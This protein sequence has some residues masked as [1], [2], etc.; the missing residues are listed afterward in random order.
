MVKQRV[1]GIWNLVLQNPM[2]QRSLLEEKKSNKQRKRRC[3]K[4]KKTEQTKI[5]WDSILK[6]SEHKNS[7]IYSK[8]E[9]T[10]S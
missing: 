8:A 3:H 1:T 2:I 6:N 10:L 5:A 7:Y 9:F 4:V